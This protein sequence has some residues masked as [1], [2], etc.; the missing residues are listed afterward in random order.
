MADLELILQ[1]LRGFHKETKEHLGLAKSIAKWNA[2]H[3]LLPTDVVN[4]LR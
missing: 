2:N 1:E 3:E 4:F